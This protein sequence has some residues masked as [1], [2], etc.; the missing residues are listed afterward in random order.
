MKRKCVIVWGDCLGVIVLSLDCLA[1]Q[2]SSVE[3][4]LSLLK[5]AFISSLERV[6]AQHR[7]NDD[8]MGDFVLQQLGTYIRRTGHESR[9]SC[10]ASGISLQS[11][12]RAGMYTIMYP[13]KYVGVQNFDGF[14]LIY[15]IFTHFQAFITGTDSLGWS[16]NPENRHKYA[17]MPSWNM[18]GVMFIMVMAL[19]KNLNQSLH[20]LCLQIIYEAIW[21]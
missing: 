11:W 8:V 1:G 3:C 5:Q 7:A 18:I 6:P 10:R 15:G 20:F 4:L 12:P 16:L 19:Q 2:D 17:Y 9:V 21:L 13:E 14:P